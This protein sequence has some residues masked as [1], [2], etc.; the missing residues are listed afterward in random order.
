MKKKDK[1]EVLTAAILIAMEFIESTTW[2]Q[3]TFQA[4]TQ[5]LTTGDGKGFRAQLLLALLL[6]SSPLS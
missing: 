2:D 6:S 4:A 1:Y 5:P 3:K